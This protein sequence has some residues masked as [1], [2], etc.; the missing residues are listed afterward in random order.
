VII[1]VWLLKKK[2]SEFAMDDQ[3]YIR[4]AS[5][6]FF[7]PLEYTHWE[8]TLSSDVFFSFLNLPFPFMMGKW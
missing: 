6:F 3:E 2:I 1:E 7:V 5:N 4:V 8:S